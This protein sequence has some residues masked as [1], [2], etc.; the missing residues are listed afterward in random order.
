MMLWIWFVFKYVFRVKSEAGI[1]VVALLASRCPFN[2]WAHTS[3]AHTAGSCFSLRH[4]LCCNKYSMSAACRL[5][6]AVVQYHASHAL[7]HGVLVQMLLCFAFGP[8]AR[9]VLRRHVWSHFGHLPYKLSQVSTGGQRC[10]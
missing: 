9:I 5:T 1:V 7:L 8:L 6:F 4:A 2:P 10:H 3:R